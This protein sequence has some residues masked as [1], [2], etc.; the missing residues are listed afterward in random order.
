MA[1]RK[2]ARHRRGRQ[3]FRQRN[4]QYN[5]FAQNEEILELQQEF[6]EVDRRR[7]IETILAS[8]TPEKRRATQAK[9][10]WITPLRRKDGSLIT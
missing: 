10:N 1:R 7:E 9:I 6:E 3:R 8:M 5:P 4:L 2:N